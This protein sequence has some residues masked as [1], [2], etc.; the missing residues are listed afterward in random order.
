MLFPAPGGFNYQYEIGT[1][2]LYDDIVAPFSFPIYKDE[3]QYIHE[4]KKA[5]E[6]VFFVFDIDMKLHSQVRREF[7]SF[8]SDLESYFKLLSLYQI[9]LARGRDVRKDSIEIEKL[10]RLISERT[11]LSYGEL[12]ILF[13]SYKNGVF[14]ISRLK[15]TGYSFFRAIYS[16]GILSMPKSK[17]RRSEILLRRS[18]KFEEVVKVNRFYDMLDAREFL[19]QIIGRNFEDNDKDI[20]VKMLYSFVRPNLIFNKDETEQ[21]IMKAREKVTRTLGVVRESEKI[22][23]RHEIVTPEVFLKLESLKRAREERG[24]GSG[25][26][27]QD[28]GRIFHIGAILAIYGIYLYMFRKRIYFNNKLLVLIAVI[29]FFEVLVAF[30]VNQVDIKLPLQYLI[31]VPTASMLLTIIFD[32][33]VAFFGTIT[34]SLII[35]AMVGNSYEFSVAFI[36]AGAIASYTVRDIKNRIQIFWSLLFIFLSYLVVI[37]GFS[38]ERQ[39]GGMNILT[40]IAFAG[41]GALLSP[42]FTYGLLIFFEKIFGIITDLSLLELSDFNH[43]LLREL[44]SRAPGTFH[45]SIMV[46]TLAEAGA[47]S[48]GANPILA[49]VGAYYHDIGKILKPEFYVEN[50]SEAIELHRKISPEESCRIIISH[51]EEGKKLAEKYRLPAEIANFIP[52]HHG[53]SLV[54]YFYGKALKRSELKHVKESDF[55]YRGPKPNSKETAIVMLADSV[56]AATRSMDEKTPENIKAMID[57]IFRSRIE[58]KQLDESNLTFKDV[59]MIKNVF[60]QILVSAYHQRVK[61][62]GQEKIEHG[63]GI[64]EFEVEHASNSGK[65]KNKKTKKARR[66]EQN[67]RGG[68]EN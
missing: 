51:V 20:V 26:L 41:G 14:R 57:A 15:N 54:A 8:V 42:I 46:A 2:W 30:I 68:G 34:I 10:R 63:V 48:I 67:S 6:E 21:L 36:I 11:G 25:G 56:E 19:K 18:N 24:I 58:D 22:I 4:L 64:I 49:R 38:L 53:T 47:K 9:K 32:S 39:E 17:L 40:K 28:V 61:Y 27:I 13:N 43:P 35:G 45:H 29:I 65:R 1:V 44:S 59:E 7:S 66:G 5:E 62:P 16:R 60:Y 12:E 55:R 37:I 23:A 52:M 33:R 3:K 50:Q 31:I